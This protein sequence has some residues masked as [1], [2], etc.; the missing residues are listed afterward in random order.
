MEEEFSTVGRS[1]RSFLNVRL[2]RAVVAIP[3]FFVNRLTARKSVS[4]AA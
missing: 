2:G 1:V 3:A 4:R